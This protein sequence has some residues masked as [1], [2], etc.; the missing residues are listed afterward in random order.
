[1]CKPEEEDHNGRRR[2][3]VLRGGSD[4][5]VPRRR[6]HGIAEC[7]ADPIV[8][9]FVLHVLLAVKLRLCSR[10]EERNIPNLPIP[11]HHSIQQIFS[12]TA[13]IVEPNSCNGL[14]PNLSFSATSANQV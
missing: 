11:L 4:H 10:Y 8:L 3:W 9:D 7:C 1:M 2:R 6:R 5:F 13:S 14:G 12:Q